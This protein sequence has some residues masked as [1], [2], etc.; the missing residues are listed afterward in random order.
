MPLQLRAPLAQDG[1]A[2]SRSLPISPSFDSVW[3]VELALK[4]GVNPTG[5]ALVV[6]LGTWVAGFS[7]TAIN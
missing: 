4:S 3:V 2:L 1:A 6:E 5:G 7:K